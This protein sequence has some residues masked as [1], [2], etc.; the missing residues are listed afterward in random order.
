MIENCFIGIGSNLGNRKKNILKALDILGT[1]E[2]IIIASSIIE[3]NPMYY[4][5]Q[6]P[7]LNAVAVIE[8]ETKPI[9]LLENLQNIEKTFKRKKTL[10]YGPRTIDLDILFYGN[11]IINEAHL[12]IPHPL[13]HEREFVLR[14]LVEIS[15]TLIHPVLKKS[16]Q[17]LLNELDC[18]VKQKT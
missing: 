6:N 5:K 2:K 4:I 1:S 18:T 15:P 14:P 8:T 3:T 10:K 9:K 13:L 12:I 11:R 16:M 7:F 17:S